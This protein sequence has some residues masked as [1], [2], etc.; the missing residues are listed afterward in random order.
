MFANFFSPLLSHRRQGQHQQES[1]ELVS[2]FHPY[3]N[4]SLNSTTLLN[5]LVSSTLGGRLLP[6]SYL[7]S[8][9][10]ELLVLTSSESPPTESRFLSIPRHPGRARSSIHGFVDLPS[11]LPFRR[12]ELTRPFFLLH[13]HSWL[14]YSPFERS[15]TFSLL[16]PSSIFLVDRYYF[17]PSSFCLSSRAQ[18]FPDSYWLEGDWK[19]I[20]R[21]IGN[22]IP[23]ELSY[24]IARAMVDLIGRGVEEEDE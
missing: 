9:T 16:T 20:L 8:H 22:A 2:L 1:K 21:Q 24:A 4:S 5:R 14:E 13:R 17:S 6:N 10:C 19:Q 7:L 18:G 12:V 15:R 23:Y 3:P 11:L